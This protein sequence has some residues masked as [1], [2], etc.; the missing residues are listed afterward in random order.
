MT[1]DIAPDITALLGRWRDGDRGAENE[2]FDAIYPALRGIASKQLNGQHDLTLNPTELAHE[3]Y[4]RLSRNASIDYQDRGHFFAVAARAA[5]HFIV[6][7]LRSRGSDKRGSGMPFVA[8]DE[9]ADELP[10][11]RIDL[12]VDWL[13]VHAALSELER[14]DE[15]SARIVELKF[16]SGLTTEEIA[17][18]VGI[19][20]ATVVRDWRFT[21]AWLAGKLRN[22]R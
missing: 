16:F 15:H 4:A 6:D 8:L 10:D 18:A 1:D 12:S 17:D 5:R 21:K 13:A 20:R 19:S 2:L 22:E 3:T 7:Y 11:Y 9:V 14:R